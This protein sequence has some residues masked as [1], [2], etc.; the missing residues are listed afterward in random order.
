M[1]DYNT[2]LK[3]NRSKGNTINKKTLVVDDL[4]I[5]P[6]TPLECYLVVKQLDEKFNIPGFTI[7]QHEYDKNRECQYVVLQSGPGWRPVKGL[8]GKDVELGITISSD[9]KRGEIIQCVERLV[10]NVKYNDETFGL[11]ESHRVLFVIE[12]E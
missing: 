5:S 7:R 8:T 4:P 3:H 12:N 11:V 6:F 2:I 9:I 10:H 1:K